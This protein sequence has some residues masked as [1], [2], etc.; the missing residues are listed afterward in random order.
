MS[1]PE[2]RPITHEIVKADTIASIARIA[3]LDAERVV[4]PAV[5]RAM[6]G[7]EVNV[8]LID[9]TFR[10]MGS[11]LGRQYLDEHFRKTVG[12]TAWRVIDEDGK[13]FFG[14]PAARLRNSQ[15]F[16]VNPEFIRQLTTTGTAVEIGGRGYREPLLPVNHI[17]RLG[18][19][20]QRNRLPWAMVRTID[21]DASDAARPISERVPA[22]DVR[23]S[24]RVVIF[25][26]LQLPSIWPTL[27]PKD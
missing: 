25:P 4:E 21:A 18:L 20:A 2:I 7:E 13:R 27:E 26:G 6:A 3:R 14:I 9:A 1:N 8:P 19:D 22:R 15:R 12:K 16:I 23:I 24:E 5:E 11:S 17:W 10:G